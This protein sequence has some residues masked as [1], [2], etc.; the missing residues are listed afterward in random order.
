MTNLFIVMARD[1]GQELQMKSDI[2]FVNG[3]NELLYNNL[4]EELSIYSTTN[5]VQNRDKWQSKLCSWN[6]IKVLG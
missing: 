1:E 6:L 3:N 4:S 2:H 5:Q